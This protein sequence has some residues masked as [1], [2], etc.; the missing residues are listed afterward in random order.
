[1]IVSAN[2]ENF[3]SW[4]SALHCM[5][6][7]GR[8]QP[9]LRTV[10]RLRS[11]TRNFKQH[12]LNLDIVQVDGG[13]RRLGGDP[14]PSRWLDIQGSHLSNSLFLVFIFCFTP[15]FFLQHIKGGQRW[16]QWRIQ[17]LPNNW[18]EALVFSDGLP[19]Q[20]GRQVVL[21]GSRQGVHGDC[22]LYTSPSPRDGLLSRMPSSA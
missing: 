18:W 5:L 6:S 1:M 2:G 13:A 17:C 3:E 8:G 21:R 16:H 7:L 4:E 22:L 10:R 15:N 14:P 19:H 11:H 20:G 9:M 12:R